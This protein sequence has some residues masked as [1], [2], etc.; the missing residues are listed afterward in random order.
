MSRLCS[1]AWLPLLAPVTSG[2]N[3]TARSLIHLG[4]WVPALGA[5]DGAVILWICT[6]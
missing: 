2:G 3:L 1:L 4:G 6:E 5:E